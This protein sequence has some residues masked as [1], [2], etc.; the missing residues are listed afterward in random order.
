MSKILSS[1]ESFTYQEQLTRLRQFILQMITEAH[2]IDPTDTSEEWRRLRGSLSTIH[3]FLKG[4]S[5]TGGA[6]LLSGDQKQDQTEL[7]E[8][9]F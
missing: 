6:G 7:N 3:T 1:L 2:L 9:D 4:S 5:G 8:A